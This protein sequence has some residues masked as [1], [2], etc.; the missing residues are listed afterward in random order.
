MEV[1][2]GAASIADPLPDGARRVGACATVPEALAGQRLD[3]VAAACFPKYSREQLKRWIQEGSLTLDGAPV[4][5]PRDPAPA[6]G[7]LRID[8]ELPPDG[9]V[10]A[11]PIALQVLH[12]DEDLIVIDKPAGLTVH[13]GAGQSDGTLQNALLH[14]DPS[15]DALPRAGIVHRLDKLTSG[16]MV[17]ARS[18]SAHTALVRAIAERAVRREYDAVV[19]GVPVAGASIDAPIGRH[20]THRTRMAVRPDGRFARTHVTVR[21]RYAAHALLR[22]R[23]D[24]GRTHQ[25]RVHLAHWGHPIVGDPQ[26]GGRGVRGSGMPE[27]LRAVIGGFGRQALHARRLELM[28]PV[29]G[30]PLCFESPWPADFAALVEAL[31]AHR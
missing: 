17:V 23:L 6:G 7:L 16:V 20:P 24:T 4:A 28:H 21:E 26:Y 10:Q 31:R 12:A 27:P 2:Q 25:I 18:L 5:R 11:Q 8:A 1:A 22:C 9:R 29:G 14:F 13:P 15:L 3:R 30:H 19:H